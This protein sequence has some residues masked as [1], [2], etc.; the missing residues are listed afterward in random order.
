MSAMTD[1]VEEVA[2]PPLEETGLPLECD[3]ETRSGNHLGKPVIV[4]GTL[5]NTSSSAVRILSWNT[6]LEPSWRGLLMEHN[7]EPVPSIAG[8]G[9]RRAPRSEDYVRIPAGG[10]VSKEIDVIEKFSVTATGDYQVSFRLPI[11]GAIEADGVEASLDQF[12]L[13][14]VESNSASF[15]IE[16]DPS[17]APGLKADVS[18]RPVHRPVGDYPSWPCLLYTSDAA[19]E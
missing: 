6:F 17:P 8:T 16:G 3:I 19:D 10:S 5:R 9:V 1:N 14:L 15:L 12:K 13:T 7:G 2:G 11:L 18:S 4:K